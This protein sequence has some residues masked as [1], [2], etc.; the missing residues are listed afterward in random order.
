[1]PGDTSAAAAA[2]VDDS[3]PGPVEDSSHTAIDMN[4]VS[5]QAMAPSAEASP[6]AALNGLHR[7]DDKRGDSHA[8]VER[9]SSGDSSLDEALAR[10]N[11]GSRR[12]PGTSH[13][14]LP[15]QPMTLTFSDVHYYVPR[16]GVRAI[17]PCFAP[18]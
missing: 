2:Q 14:N 3:S 13:M 8:P 6:Q 4:A 12:R 11:H 18:A 9:S 17:W 16:T 15:F 7:P 5:A 1:M 10:I